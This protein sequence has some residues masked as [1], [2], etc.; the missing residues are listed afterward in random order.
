MT[1]HDNPTDIEEF[2][3]IGS[4]TIESIGTLGMLLLKLC[5]SD[6]PD[7]ADIRKMISL[8][9][10]SQGMICASLSDEM[11]DKL[12]PSLDDMF[13]IGRNFGIKFGFPKAE[14]TSDDNLLLNF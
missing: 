9:A 1:L 5:K 6:I 7:K 14:I 8:L 2:H 4:E 11:V 12:L 3:K 13:D 10:Y